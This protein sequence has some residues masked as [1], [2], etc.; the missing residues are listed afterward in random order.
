MKILLMRPALPATAFIKQIA[1]CEPLELELLA[2][3]V[4]S[5][6]EVELYDMRVDE[7]PLEKVINSTRPHLI[8]ITGY[9]MDVPGINK[10]SQHIKNI[11]RNII[12]VVG[13]EHASHLPEDFIDSIDYIFR[14]NALKT[15][16]KFIKDILSGEKPPRIIQEKIG[17]ND[18]F[19]INPLRSISSKYSKKYRFGAASPISLAQLSAGCKYRCS[20]CSIPTRQ[21]LFQRRRID[22]SI[23]H[24]A[25]CPAS[26]V[27]CIDSNALQDVPEAIELFTEI[28]KAKLGKKLMI[29]CRSDTIANNPSLPEL[30]K[31]ADVSVVAFG[32]ESFD[33]RTLRQF[34]KA[35]TSSNNEKAVKLCHNAGLLVRGNFIIDQSFS[36]DDFRY[37]IDA[38]T[39][40]KIE[41]PS[42][43]ILT[44]LPGTKFFVD[45]RKDWITN[46][47]SLFDLSHSVL[48]TKLPIEQFHE[49]FKNL[50]TEL[51]SIRRLLWI[52]SRIPPSLALKSLGAIAT[53]FRRFHYNQFPV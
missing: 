39:D 43:S 53:T 30:L 51:Y 21:P 17:V 14:N 22:D 28:S 35:N 9:T 3:T 12:I 37:F 27:L 34:R 20:Y 29:S 8:A 32:L 47:Y 36:V 40:S 48:P 41:F 52:A 2:A 31:K 46:D 45:S 13:G 50:F 6:H 18:I 11:D 4:S 38:V 16:P 15:F 26:H 44:P 19:D 7:R 33:N 5:H 49:Q 10:T 25:S 42:M 24:L 23:I 1:V